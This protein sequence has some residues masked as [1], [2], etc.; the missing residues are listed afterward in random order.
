MHFIFSTGSLYSYGIDRCFDF[1]QRAG[2]DGIE[3][4]IDQRWDTRQANYVAKLA[5]LYSQPVRAVHSPFIGNLGGWASDLPGG[6]EKSVKVAEEVGA[7]VVILHL[8]EKVS[9]TPIY[10]GSRRLLLPQPWANRHEKYIRWVQEG[11]PR[12]Q[13]NTN[14][15]LAIENLPAK[16]VFGRRVNPIKWNAH[17]RASI[18]DITRFPHI[19]LDTTHLGTWGL[20]PAEIFLRW[21]DRVKHVHLSNFNGKEHRRPEDGHLRLDQL[22]ARMAQV[23]YQHTVSLELHPDALSAGADEERIVSLLK[24]SLDHCRRWAQASV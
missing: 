4:L 8:P 6:I 9:Y 13:E 18:S 1:A 3:L 7:A 12:L 10:I 20:D 14:V 23:G 17:N 5:E 19:T 15:F 21:R 22:L 11:M 24:T 16:N 2:F